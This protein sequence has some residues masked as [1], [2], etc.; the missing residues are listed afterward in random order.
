MRYNKVP[1]KQLRET[2][3]AAVL[4]V[5]TPHTAMRWATVERAGRG[6]KT[7]TIDLRHNIEQYIRTS[8]YRRSAVLA[9]KFAKDAA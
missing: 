8:S 2:N 6:Y 1:R 4:H 3:S 9:K 7:C 5:M